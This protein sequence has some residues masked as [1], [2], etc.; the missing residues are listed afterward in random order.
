MENNETKPKEIQNKILL[1][2]DFQQQ[3]LIAIEYAVFFAKKT[4]SELV[5]LHVIEEGNF[6][7]KMFTSD[8]Q[9]KQI[10]L[11]AQKMLSK[12]SCRVVEE[13]L[14]VSTLTEYGKVY[15]KIINIANE[16]NPLFIIMGKSETPS[17]VRTL[18]G[19]NAIKVIAHSKSPVI[20]IRGNNYVVET[21]NTK[22]IVLPLDL[23]KNVSQQICAATR[24]GKLLNAPIRILTIVTEESVALEVKLLTALKKAQKAIEATGVKCYT[25]LMKETQRPIHD[26]VL[27]FAK[28]GNPQLV[29][30]MTQQSNIIDSFIGSSANGFIE[31]SDIPVLTV[32]PWEYESDETF[33]TTFT[34][35]LGLISK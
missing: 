32:N 33:I 15:E 31:K 5:I 11:E 34:D 22:D 2:I 16:I 30:V 9:K 20:T 23:T 8:E 1:P 13:G 25:K 6:I 17:F 24:L 3:S 7:T 19:S 14:R 18:V 29:I 4:N 27:D 21:E 28:E 35:P 26:V 12:L 10:T